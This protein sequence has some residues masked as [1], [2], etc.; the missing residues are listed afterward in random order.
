MTAEKT[1]A[2]GAAPADVP[3]DA[4]EK[5]QA[6]A[7]SRNIHQRRLA[8]MARCKAIVPDREHFQKFRYVSIQALEN[9][10]REFIVAEGLDV[11]TSFDLDHPGF[12]QVDQVNADDPDDTLRTYWPVVDGDKG[13]AYTVKYPL[14]R[15]FHIGDGEEGDEAEMAKKSGQTASR[16]AQGRS[17]PPN[18][19]PGRSAAPATGTTPPPAVFAHPP[20]PV[21]SG[22]LGRVGQAIALFATLA[23]EDAKKNAAWAALTRAGWRRGSGGIT[24][25]PPNRFIPSLSIEALA[26]LL[27]E[28]RDIEGREADE[29][30][31]PVRES[32]AILGSS[33][34]DIDPDEIPF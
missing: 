3:A 14:M 8:V 13:W 25:S 23:T 15:L 33:A 22:G 34:G 6:A 18:A 7:P 2:N 4:A 31:D 32:A 19:P 9:R 5:V 29:S 30:P 26:T 12:V 1:T 27:A 17:S 28:L 16:S 11:V 21:V 24:G 20:E 10:L